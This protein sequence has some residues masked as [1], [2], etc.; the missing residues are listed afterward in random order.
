MAKSAALRKKEQR[1]REAQHLIDVGASEIKLT[2]YR[3]TQEDLAYLQEAGE[4]EQAEEVITLLI[5]NTAQI[6]KRDMSQ[7]SEL[8]KVPRHENKGR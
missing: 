6:L 4:F 8:L 7:I 2:I 3:S 1:E 5:K